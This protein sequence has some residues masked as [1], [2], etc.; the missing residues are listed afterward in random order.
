MARLF[1]AGVAWLTAF[2][3]FAALVLWSARA[4][5]PSPTPPAVT[6]LVRALNRMESSSTATRHEPWT[7][8]RATSANRAM[9]I[10]VEADVPEDARK[11]ADEIVEPLRQKYE[12]VLIYVRANGNPLNAI[13][14][15][16]QWTPHGGFI[17]TSY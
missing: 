9:V 13:V 14:R 2:G 3:L 1:A 15:R 12:E 5:P 6:N 10:D 7:V 8:T 16:I 4:P 11:I 17:E